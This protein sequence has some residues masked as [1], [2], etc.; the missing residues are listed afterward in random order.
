[1]NKYINFYKSFVIKQPVR[2]FEYELQLED[3]SL[4]F[5]RDE[6]NPTEL[7]ERGFL[8]TNLFGDDKI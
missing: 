4:I 5:P 2:E 6:K 1:M 7:A 8:V 3:L